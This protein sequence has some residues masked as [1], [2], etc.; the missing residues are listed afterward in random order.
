MFA[1]CHIKRYAEHR[2][3]MT[4]LTPAHLLHFLSLSASRQVLVAPFFPILISHQA[5]CYCLCD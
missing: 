1:V 5:V 3:A 2:V 4:V